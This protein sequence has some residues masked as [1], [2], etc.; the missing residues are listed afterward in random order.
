MYVMYEMIVII[1]AEIIVTFAYIMLVDGVD[2]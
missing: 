2:H 1:L